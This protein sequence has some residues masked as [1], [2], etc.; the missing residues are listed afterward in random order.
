M[1]STCPHCGAPAPDEARF[2]MKCG[3]ER[4]PEPAAAPTAPPPPAYVPATGPVTP[5]PVGAFFGRTF[6]GDW[7]GAVRA[8]VWPLVLLLVG[9]VALASPS[10]GQ[11]DEVVVGFVDRLR[12]S[13]A[14]LLQSVG[15]GFEL[16]GHEQRPAFGGTTDLGSGSSDQ[17]LQGTASLH[18][19][20]L[21]VTALWIVALLIGVRVL[22]TRI[23][24]RAGAGAGATAPGGTAG[25]EAA[26]RVTLLVTAGVLALALFAQPDIMSVEVSSSPVLAA[27]GALL[28]G[29]VVSYG[30][31]HRDDLAHRLAARPGAQAAVRAAGT[32]LRALVVVLVLCSVVA[33]ISL[34]QV[35]DLGELTDLDDSDISPLLVALLL[36]PNLAVTALGIGWGASAEASVSGGSSMY[37]GSQ[38]SGSFGLAELGDVTNDWAIVGALALGLVCALAVGVIAAR[39]GPG[40]RGEQFLA[41]GL[42]FGLVLLLAGFSGFGVE[43]SGDG[44]IGGGSEFGGISGNGTVETGISVP[45]VLLFGML[46]LAA[47]TFLAPFLLQMAGERALPAHPAAPAADPAAPAA[48]PAAPAADPAAP[49]ADPAAPAAD[50]TAPTVHPAAPAVPG[51]LPAPSYAPTL[52]PEAAPTP[53]PGA[54]PVP[55]VFHD[56]G[57][58]HLGQR[59]PAPNSR[60]SAGIWV[61]TIAGAL[62]I[63]GGAAA[64]ILFWQDGGDDKTDGAAKDA[65]SSASQSP[66]PQ[67]SPVASGATGSPEPDSSGASAS[68]GSSDGSGGLGVVNVPD[69]SEIMRDPEGFSFAAP[70]GW[71]REPVDPQRPGQI[72]YAGS[73]GREEFLVGVVTDAPYTSY[74]NFLNIEKHTKSAPDKSDYQRVRLE[75]NTFQGRSG[76]IWEYTYTD[77]SDRTIHAIDQS[78]IAENGTEYAIQFSWREDF[79]PAGEGAK[80]H[81]TALDTWRLISD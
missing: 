43:A 81:Q 19:V 59:P 74:E 78:Y 44:G 75:R 5:S 50:P 48:D 28:L 64:G 65:K 33:F 31:L 39:R 27:L 35:D 15:G 23:L 1:A 79:L 72:T 14:L 10:Y 76:A 58:F 11:D 22:R 3:R 57:A 52:S 77:G 16:S 8:A 25:L 69:G 47:A 41:A 55:A 2:C 13:L 49:A 38:E 70:A 56:P 71:R 7:A 21:T 73:T 12:V 34:A 42:F 67:P 80:T 24:T 66:S 46:W 9:A 37:G 62:V 6:R 4:A 54:A 30:V 68:S 17:V 63:G 32:A 18:F 51:A 53:P 26:V 36:L 20:P 61:A 29:F 45:E 40:R 60:G